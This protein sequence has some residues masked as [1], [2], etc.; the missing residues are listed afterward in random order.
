MKRGIDVHGGNFYGQRVKDGPL[1]PAPPGRPDIV[2]CRRVADYDVPLPAHAATTNCSQCAAPIA[3]NP[4]GPHQDVK[5]ICMQC[6]RI[7]PLP[8][9]GDA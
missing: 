3:F 4:Q 8:M 2:V 5:K 6:A 1:E 9:R 7:Q